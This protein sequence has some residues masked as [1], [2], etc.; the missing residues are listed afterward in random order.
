MVSYKKNKELKSGNK[1]A[2]NLDYLK[3]LKASDVYGAEASAPELLEDWNALQKTPPKCK[4]FTLVEK[5]FGQKLCWSLRDLYG[6]NTSVCGVKW[7]W[8]LHDKDKDKED[9]LIAKH[10]H[11]YLEFENPRSF[12]SVA[13]ELGI[14]VTNLC[15]VYKKKQMLE[16][17]THENATD[18][19]HY[20]VED[21]HSNFDIE[22]AKNEEEIDVI[23]EFEDYCAYKDGLITYQ[24]YFN[25]YSTYI[26]RHSFSKRQEMYE[27]MRNHSRASPNV[28]K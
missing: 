15:K 3:S 28:R 16:Y 5:H 1:S 23:Q 20:P 26:V 4:Y 27:R 17:L 22:A 11:I 12:R 10:Y 6:D 13:N 21:I 8:I 24:D 25:K 9:D 2:S 7:A 19:F 18:K 14:P